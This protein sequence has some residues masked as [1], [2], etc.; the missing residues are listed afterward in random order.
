MGVM[1]APIT[2]D[3]DNSRV[4]LRFDGSM[5]HKVMPCSTYIRMLHDRRC[6]L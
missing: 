5:D 4:G 1:L 2:F 3:D 6:S